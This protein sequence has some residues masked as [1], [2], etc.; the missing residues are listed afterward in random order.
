MGSR[1]PDEFDHSGGA[2]GEL[3][4]RLSGEAELESGR[5][6]HDVSLQRLNL[7]QD[8]GQVDYVFGPGIDEPLAVDTAGQVSI[9]SQDGLNS[10]PVI[11]GAE[12]AIESTSV[13]DSWGVLSVRTG[14]QVGSLGYAARELSELSLYYSRNR[15][16]EPGS[17]RFTQ[18]DRSFASPFS[19]FADKDYLG[20]LGRSYRRAHPRLFVPEIS[21]PNYRS[22]VY[23]LNNP[24][25]FIDPLGRKP[26]VPGCDWFPDCLETPPIRRCCDIHDDCYAKNGC[27]WPSWLLTSPFGP[28]GACNDAAAAC[29]IPKLPGALNPV[30]NPLLLPIIQGSILPPL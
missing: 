10:V 19:P 21:D 12:S 27:A 20:V 2:D 11:S 5:R 25:H 30:T 28:C 1:E 18:E 23:V 8:V 4:L 26:Q 3:C 7:I 16:Y 24:I 22:Y 17:G 9:Y 15:Y 29:I 6:I 13:W 14:T